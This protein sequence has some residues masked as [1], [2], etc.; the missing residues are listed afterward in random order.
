MV[1]LIFLLNL[2]MGL[3]LSWKRSCQIHFESF[4][5]K[6]HGCFKSIDHWW[7][8]VI[9]WDR[10]G[11]AVKVRRPRGQIWGRLYKGWW[12]MFKG[13]ERFHPLVT[14]SRRQSVAIIALSADK[15]HEILDLHSLQFNAL[16]AEISR[17]ISG[18]IFSFSFFFYEIKSNQ[19]KFETISGT[20]LLSTPLL[21]HKLLKSFR[22]K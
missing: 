22:V 7:L 2:G 4:N 14:G 6:R 20:K 15:T 21:R 9:C 18:A 11:E 12:R 5:A 19:R 1:E 10:A 17:E 13:P 16:S 8:T 3:I